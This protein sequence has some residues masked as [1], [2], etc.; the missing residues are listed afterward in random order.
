MSEIDSDIL[1]KWTLI[2]SVK[3]LMG[4]TGVFS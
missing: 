4:I 2:G 3:W 1:P